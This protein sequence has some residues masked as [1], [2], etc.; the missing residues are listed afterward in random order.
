MGNFS[1]EIC[2]VE[3]SSV[4][5]ACATLV[6]PW[7]TAHLAF[8]SI[9]NSRS[10]LKPMSIESLRPFNHLILCHPLRPLT[11]IP[12]SFRDFCNESTL[13]IWWLKYWTFSFS[14]SPSNEHPGLISFTMDW[15]DLLA[16]QRTLN[17]LLQ[18]QSSKPS[19]FLHSAVITVQLSHPYMTTGKTIDT[20]TTLVEWSW[21][22]LSSFLTPSISHPHTQ[23]FIRSLD[24]WCLHHGMLRSLGMETERWGRMSHQMLQ[25]REHIFCPTQY[26]VWGVI[27]ITCF[28]IP[29]KYRKKE[30]RHYEKTGCSPANMYGKN[31]KLFLPLT[32]KT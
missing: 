4:A 6:T 9:T 17:S 14:I 21:H 8:L 27:K 30:W 18:C 32:S 16:V 11:T 26:Y 10:L 23:S 20:Q 3:F 1:T 5:Q 13:C 25:K 24:F 28:R 31:N 7:I 2:S 15:L 19:I 22:P 29:W 12:P